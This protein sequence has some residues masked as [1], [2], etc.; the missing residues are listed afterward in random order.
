VE[1]A[2]V[3]ALQHLTGNQ[4]AALLLFEVLGFS[5][6]EIAT[7]MN[8]STTSVNSALARARKIVAQKVPARSQQQTLR[9]LDDARLR[10]LVTRF[11]SAFERGD[12][13]ALVA[14]LTEDVT[15]SMPPLAHWYHGLAAVKD[16]AVQV[17]MTLCPS[18]RHR[19]ISANGQPAVAFYVG[20]DASGQHVAWSI[21]ILT[22]RGDRI[23]E[24]T[25]FLG[26][27]HF[28]PFRLPASLP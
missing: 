23:S 7:I 19:Q 13:D 9:T 2:F 8:T 17:P 5:A 22:L 3:A 4:R 26:P 20:N 12:A 27:D 10:E 6:G 14:L 28:P 25:S 1:L 24:I 15:W 11:A 18:W 16:F 21:T